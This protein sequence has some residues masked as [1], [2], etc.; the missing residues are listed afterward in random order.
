MPH[1]G[2]QV[3]AQRYSTCIDN[4]YCNFTASYITTFIT[5]P[6]LRYARAVRLLGLFCVLSAL[7]SGASLAVAT[8][9]PCTKVTAQAFVNPAEA[10]TCLRSFQAC[11]VAEEGAVGES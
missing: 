4:I 7:P 8:H 1:S 9:D 6:F 10:M 3:Q 5:R 2:T 11:Y